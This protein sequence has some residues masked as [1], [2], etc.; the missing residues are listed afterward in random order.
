MA[1]YL[2]T[3]QIDVDA[4]TPE[5]AAQTAREYQIDTETTANV[6]AVFDKVTKEETIIDLMNKDNGNK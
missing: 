4:D 3:W 6:F 2:V 1:S 5:Q